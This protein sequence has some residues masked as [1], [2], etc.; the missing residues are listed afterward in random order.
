[1]A[2]LEPGI[3]DNINPC[4]HQAAS[5][6]GVLLLDRNEARINKQSINKVYWST[7]RPGSGDSVS[8]ELQVPTIRAFTE[9]ACQPGPTSNSDRAWPRP[10]KLAF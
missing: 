1:M 8:P 5:G 10:Q 3:T 6:Q 9:S 7:A 2:G 4:L